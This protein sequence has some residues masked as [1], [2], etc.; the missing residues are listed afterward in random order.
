M[1]KY[2]AI[3]LT[4][5][6]S[7]A[8]ADECAVT[9]ESNDMMQFNMTAITAP[10]TCDT[11]TVTLKHT[12]QLDKKY[13]GHN[14]VLSTTADAQAI[15]GG[16]LKAGADNNYLPPGDKT[17]IAATKII[18]GGEQDTVTFDMSKLSSA[19]DYTFFCSFPGHFAIM[20]GSFVVKG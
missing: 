20:K 3:F 15:V 6:S 12:G 18:G 11:F 14:W 17:I 2:V 16:A 10:A 4:L 7:V 8:F 13:M 1:R 5:L 9:I 19:E